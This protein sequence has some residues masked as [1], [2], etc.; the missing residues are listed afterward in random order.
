MGTLIHDIGK[1]GVPDDILGKP[2]KLT[3]EEFEVIKRHP[4]TGYRMIRDIP[5]FKDCAP[6]VRWHHEKLD[7]K[8]YPDGLTGSEI[9][10]LV[11]IST[12]ADMFDAMTSNRAYRGSLGAAKAVEELRKDAMRNIVNPELVEVWVKLLIEDGAYSEPESLRKAA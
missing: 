9:P 7:G 2:D 10:L 3:G 6:I 1:I 12:I 4:V 11:Q 8:G 5:F